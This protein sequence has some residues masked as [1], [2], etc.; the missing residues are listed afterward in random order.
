MRKLVVF[1]IALFA[2]FLM[3]NAYASTREVGPG[4]QETGV[5]SSRL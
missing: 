3:I 4:E 5:E 1:L 2:I